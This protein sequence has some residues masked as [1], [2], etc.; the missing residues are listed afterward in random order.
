MLN[1]KK[2]RSLFNKKTPL[3]AGLGSKQKTF[4]NC[5]EIYQKEL[6]LLFENQEIFFTERTYRWACPSPLP[7]FILVRFLRTPPPSPT[8][9]RTYFL[10][11]PNVF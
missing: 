3:Y 10:N 8:A 6:Y 5:Q 11:E 4:S 2:C 1:E 9:R 7:L